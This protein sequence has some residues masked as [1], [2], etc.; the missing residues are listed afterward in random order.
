MIPACRLGALVLVGA[1]VAACSPETGAQSPAPGPSP[2]DLSP[3]GS[4]P[5]TA[6]A[7]GGSLRYGLSH[8]PRAL[9]PGLAAQRTD[10][11]VDDEDL[12]V[13][14][15][16]FDS[17]TAVGEDLGV[18]PAAAERWEVSQD[19]TVVTF[20]LRRDGLF[21]D[22]TPVTAGSFARSWNG[23]ADGTAAV[24]S[25]IAYRL[26]PV[27]GFQASQEQGVPLEGLEIVDR[28]TLRVRLSGAFHDFPM[29][30]SHPGLGPLPRAA[31]RP[32]F[33]D[34]PV[35]NGPFRMAEPWQREQFVRV[36]RFE[37]HARRPLLA[38]IVFRVFT[39]TE[40]EADAY[41]EFRATRLHVAPVPADVLDAAASAYGRSPDGY[42]G[43]GVLHGDALTLYYY[44]FNV[45]LA[46]FDDPEVRRALSL[47]V[48]REAITGEI[49]AGTRSPATSMV[50]PPVPGYRPGACMW[51][52][53]EPEEAAALLRGKGL[54]EIRLV[55]DD[56]PANQAIAQRFQAD[57][58]AATD[59]VVSLEPVDFVELRA[60]VQQG[61]IGFFRLGW[62]AD[63]P[64]MDEF[65]APLFSS[66]E[67][68]DTNF[69]RYSEPAVD[70]L[71]EQAR[72]TAEPQQ[73][74]A[75]YQQAEERIMADAPLAPVMFQRL[76]LVAD[77]SVRDLWVSPMGTPNLE[78]VWLAATP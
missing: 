43:P 46:P 22:G 62:P 15:A 76:S 27:A 67:L 65:L 5:V 13:L 60:G 71:L 66:R 78:A 54:G 68:S 12:V 35:G 42:H 63:L 50:A 20:H 26:A 21:H 64:M 41:G 77:S 34:E 23:I 75:L 37:R 57:V 74:T 1:L 49:M 72:A 70:D 39:G 7:R 51:C 4:G 69:S 11:T 61:E 3:T 29:V 32:T 47:L 16:L 17:L 48:N 45:R 52:R 59:V 10:L 31:D 8:D 36:I 19:G 44:G 56:H 73:R 25:P 28:Y 53:F 24:P 38:E 40:A 14:D 2:G 18:V 58:H 6:P 30:V 9:V 55:Y 33:G